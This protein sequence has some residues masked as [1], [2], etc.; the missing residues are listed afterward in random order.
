MNALAVDEERKVIIVGTGGGE[1]FEVKIPEK[2]DFASEKKLAK[3]SPCLARGHQ[4]Q[5]TNSQLWGL[6]G[7]FDV[8][9]CWY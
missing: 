5:S 2:G 1:I 9:P 8:L 3:L 7:T 6:A 4:R